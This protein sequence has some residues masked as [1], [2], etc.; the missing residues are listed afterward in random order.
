MIGFLV[1]FVFTCFIVW[2]LWT[3]SPEFFELKRKIEEQERERY[4]PWKD[5]ED[6]MGRN[7]K[8]ED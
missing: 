1:G 7:S 6:W 4:Q 8:D 5:G 2:L 3:S